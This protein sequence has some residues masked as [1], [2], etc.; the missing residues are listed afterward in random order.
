MTLGNFDFRE[1]DSF[2]I[3]QSDATHMKRR[4]PERFEELQGIYDAQLY[5]RNVEASR[6]IGYLLNATRHY[7]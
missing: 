1:C 3:A 6:N 5:A 7:D 4:A 2:N